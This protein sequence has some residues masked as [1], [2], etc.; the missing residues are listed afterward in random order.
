MMER[1]FEHVG[2]KYYKGEKLEDCHP[3]LSYQTGV[4]PESVEKARNHE[5]IVNSLTGDDKPITPYPVEYDAK[6]R[7]F[8]SIG[9]RPECLENEIPKV[10]PKAFPE[11]EDKMN[12]WGN[13]MIKAVG[14]A[15][16]MAAVGMGLDQNTFTDRMH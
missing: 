8:W 12:S 2:E 5:E 7:F 11:W 16:E 6:W 15:A 9:E 3:E 13:H 4:T 10:Y 1:Y 14:T